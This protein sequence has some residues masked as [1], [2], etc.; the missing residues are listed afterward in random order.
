MRDARRAGRPFT[1][2]RLIAHP[3]GRH[4]RRPSVELLRLRQHSVHY[5]KEVLEAPQDRFVESWEEVSLLLEKVTSWS[6]MVVR[7]AKNRLDAP[8]DSRAGR[9]LRLLHCGCAGVLEQ[10]QVE[11]L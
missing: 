8:Y 11:V 4:G 2:Q 3:S 1:P 9:E 7:I 10:L 6:M 5:L